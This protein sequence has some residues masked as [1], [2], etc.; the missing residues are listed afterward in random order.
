LLK[1]LTESLRDL[2]AEGDGEGA[3][4][5]I[6]ALRAISEISC[7]ALTNIVTREAGELCA[8]EGQELIATEQ[9][10]PNGTGVVTRLREVRQRRRPV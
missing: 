7:P 2:I 6:E 5:A 8:R 9:E 10:A 1:A 4:V 3:K